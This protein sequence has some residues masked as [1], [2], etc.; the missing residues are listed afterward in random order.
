MNPIKAVRARFCAAPGRLS[1]FKHTTSVKM[2]ARNT[3]PDSCHS[4]NSWLS[5]GL[6]NN[7]FPFEL[8]VVAEVHE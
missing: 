5:I 6:T 8:C 1:S 4:C 2:L 7:A 3:N